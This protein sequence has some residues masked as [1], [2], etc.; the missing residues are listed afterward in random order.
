[1]DKLCHAQAEIKTISDQFGGPRDCN[2]NLFAQR[3]TCPSSHHVPAECEARQKLI[4]SFDFHSKIQYVSTVCEPSV[5]NLLD[6]SS[7]HIS[8]LKAVVQYFLEVT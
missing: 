4:F 7:L 6:S 3:P 2:S 8:L 5:E 1:M